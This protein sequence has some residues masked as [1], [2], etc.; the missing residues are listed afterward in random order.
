MLRQVSVLLYLS[1]SAW[2]ALGTHY[3][4]RLVA[5]LPPICAQ[6]R[7]LTCHSPDQTDATSSCN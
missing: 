2:Y 5:H 7:V 3:H 6:L 4:G 1:S